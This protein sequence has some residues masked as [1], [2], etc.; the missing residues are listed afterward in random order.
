[1][2]LK[3]NKLDA[4]WRHLKTALDLDPLRPEVYRLGANI[5]RRQGRF[6]DADELLKRA[7]K[8]RRIP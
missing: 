8:L 5:L 4:A 3:Q 1:M 2:L 6:D 7:L